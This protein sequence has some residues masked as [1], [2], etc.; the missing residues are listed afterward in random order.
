M[1]VPACSPNKFEASLDYMGRPYHF[2]KRSFIL[3][4]LFYLI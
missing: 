4:E 1:V 3:F 2:L